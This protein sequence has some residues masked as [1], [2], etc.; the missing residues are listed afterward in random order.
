MTL[1]HFSRLFPGLEN[2]STN[3]K[4]FSIIQESIR[5]LKM[6]LHFFKLWHRWISLELI[7]WG[8][9]SERNICCCLFISSITHEIRHFQR[10]TC[11][12]SVHIKTYCF[13]DLLNAWS[14]SLLKLPNYWKIS[15]PFLSQGISQACISG[16]F[17][18]QRC[19][20]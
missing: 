19:S 7:S 8:Q 13:F 1:F 4:T 9:Y 18:L 6:T 16:R 17:L 15:V 20:I 11:Q 5:T 12:N 10:E 2:C 3:F 14:S